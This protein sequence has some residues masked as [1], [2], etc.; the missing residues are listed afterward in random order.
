MFTVL[1]E[2][3]APTRGTKQSACV[4]L[5]AK[6]GV[7]IGAGEIVLIPLGVKINLEKLKEN[8]IEHNKQRDIKAGLPPL[9]NAFEN[10]H[11]EEEFLP[12]HQLNLHIRS[13]MS[14]KHK[15]VIANGTGIIDL[16]YPDEIMIC[17]HKP[18]TAKDI[19]PTVFSKIKSLFNQRCGD[20]DKKINP[21]IFK[22]GDKIAQI[23]LIE[24]KTYLLGIESD[25]I[26]KGGFGS[27]N[28]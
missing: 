23:E 7:E 8:Y 1:D 18:I 20:K 14:A 25:E 24:H 9:S 3:C 12:S 2:M 16:D 11:F 28:K 26:R 17:I 22:K 5:Y 13:S 19:I 27:T 4:D 10:K 15:L 21:F 6:E